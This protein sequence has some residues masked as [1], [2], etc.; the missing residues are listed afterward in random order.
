MK[1]YNKPISVVSITDFR[2]NITPIKWKIEG[3]DGEHLTYKITQIM[4]R[5]RKRIAGKTSI[6]IV[7]L[8]VINGIEKPCELRYVPDNTSWSLFKI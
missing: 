6:E 8:T 2:G 5:D 1:V 4:K 3:N 7:C